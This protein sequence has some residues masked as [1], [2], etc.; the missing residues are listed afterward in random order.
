MMLKKATLVLFCV[1]SF[2]GC[3]RADNNQ[4]LRNQPAPP[5][6]ADYTLR[7]PEG[8]QQ[9][10][11]QT[12]QTYTSPI[13]FTPAQTKT[14]YYFANNGAAASAPSNEGYYREL[15][16]KTAEGKRVVQDFYQSS[17]TPQTA[18]FVL[19]DDADIA[20]FDSDVNN[21]RI[22]WFTRGGDVEEMGDYEKGKPIGATLGIRHGKAVLATEKTDNGTT[23]YTLDDNA[24]IASALTERG[25]TTC[26]IVFYPS[27]SAMFQG[28]I[29]ADT[30]T[31]ATTYCWNEA[32]QP[33]ACDRIQNEVEA[34]L[35]QADSLA[36]S[37]SH[38]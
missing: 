8:W 24:R 34:G 26:A 23:V 5:R 11:T 15:L 14:V 4:A 18:P 31:F 29:P 6:T 22:V 36:R 9:I 1:F 37:L 3:Y 25:N 7:L 10:A 2:S 32:A 21:G 38:N 13:A 28:D 35:Q 30:G 12:S 27:G 33:I 20:S 17:Q 16:G 19:E